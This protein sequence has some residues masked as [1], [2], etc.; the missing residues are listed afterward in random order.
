MNQVT[1]NHAQGVY[2]LTHAEGCSCL[3]FGNAR[4]HA[5][6]IASLLRR[7]DLAFTAEDHAAPSGY[8]KY[9]RAVQA[10]AQSPMTQRTYFDPG[11]DP[12][13]ARVLEACRRDGRKLRLILGDTRTGESWLDGGL[14]RA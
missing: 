13:A 7:A 9:H 4:G 5:D 11:T 8:E 3:G 10:W 1:L 6:Q 12:K 2:V 14:P